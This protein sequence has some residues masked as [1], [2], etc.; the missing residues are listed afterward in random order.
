MLRRKLL[1]ALAGIG[2]LRPFRWPSARRH[3]IT[4]LALAVLVVLAGVLGYGPLTDGAANDVCTRQPVAC[5]LVTNLLSSIIVAFLVSLLWIGTISRWIVLRRHLRRIRENPRRLG[6]EPGPGTG[7]DDFIEPPGVLAMLEAELRSGAAGVPLIVTGAAGSGKTMLLGRLAVRLAEQGLVPVMLSMRGRHPGDSVTALARATFLSQ[8]DRFVTRERDG[9]QIWRKAADQR[10]VVVLVDSLDEMGSDVGLVDVRELTRALLDRVVDEDVGLVLAAR[11][12]SL[13]A[14]LPGYRFPM[15]ALPVEETVARLAEWGIPAPLGGE[16]TTRLALHQVP[17]Y[18]VLC[19]ELAL[20]ELSEVAGLPGPVLG[21]RVALLD[22]VIA[23]RTADAAVSEDTLRVLGSIAWTQI[24]FGHTVCGVEDY[25]SA[26]E[27]PGLGRRPQNRGE[28][29]AVLRAAQSVGVLRMGLAQGQ[30]AFRHPLLL[31][32]VASLSVVDGLG[33]GRGRRFLAAVLARTVMREPIMALE[34][35]LLRQP[36]PA[37]ARRL[38]SMAE[39]LSPVAPVLRNLSLVNMLASVAAALSDRRLKRRCLRLYRRLWAGA[40]PADRGAAVPYVGLLDVGRS[41]A[42]LWS[43]LDLDDQY[44]ARWA[45]AQ[46]LAEPDV[47]RFMGLAEFVDGFTARMRAPD[48]P[49]QGSDIVERAFWFIP[50]LADGL[51]AGPARDRA[52]GHLLELRRCLEQLALRDAPGALGAESSLAQGYKLAA[53]RHPALPPDA[54]ACELLRSGRFWYARLE[55]VQAVGRRLHHNPGDPRALGALR[56]ARRD[57]HP[58]VRAM[59][60]LAQRCADEP[61]SRLLWY[62]EESLSGSAVSALAPEALQL[63]GEVTLWLNHNEKAEQG[64]RDAN[65]LRSSLPRCMSARASR[66]RLTGDEPCG[67]ECGFGLC[68]YTAEATGRHS[69]DLL[70]EA[71]CRSIRQAGLRA[72]TPA[73]Y[74]SSRR[75]EYTAI[76]R[77]LETFYQN[78]MR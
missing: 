5:G 1:A 60:A 72:G 61:W 75:K 76:W 2:E 70:N 42:F 30:I 67:A 38:M 29:L 32:H 23:R 27:S 63:L 15:P 65:S 71:I 78:R 56:D 31:S 34:T 62:S 37:C 41:G 28:L 69:R 58:F 33:S 36:S 43:I 46:L 64:K 25:L 44:V 8:I 12:E 39:E 4:S 19:R 20:D 50:A 73:W 40:R 11:P 48:G 74:D 6:A 51:P 66:S 26:G 10:R 24:R 18:A 54:G 68:P 45:C 35:A 52:A 53:F 47:E 55:A 17:F 16:L 57:S 21:R 49:A 7:A 59:A 77:T 22:S 13:P 3:P 14:V 9:E